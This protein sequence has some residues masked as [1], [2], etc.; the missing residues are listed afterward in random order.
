MAT[1]FL[2][3]ILKWRN[4]SSKKRNKNSGFTVLELL[5]ATLVA[6]FVIVALLDLVVDLLQTDRRE[7]A[8][9]ETQRE[10]Q[11]ALDFMVN[12]IREAAYIYDNNGLNGGGPDNLPGIK[13]YVQIPDGYT[14]ILAFW[15]PETISDADMQDLGDCGQFGQ[16]NEKRTECDLLLIR[17]RAFSLVIYMQK[18]NDRQDALGGWK[19][20]SRIARLQI[21]KYRLDGVGD[22]TKTTGY[23]DPQENTVTFATWPLDGNRTNRQ[24]GIAQGTTQVLVDFVD[25]PTESRTS[26]LYSDNLRA[27]D[28]PKC[29]DEQNYSQIPPT[30]GAAFN[31]P[32]FM[33]CVSTN[34][35]SGTGSDRSNANQDVLIFLRGNPTGKA[36]VK[37][38]PLLAVKTQAVARGVVDKQQGAQ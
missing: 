21:P 32:S 31:R 34:N 36:G 28:N 18:V 13:N 22:L 38:A 30:T 17:R 4:R 11:M 9:N 1:K 10:I 16:N 19:G 2:E 5:V 33:V 6:T 25:Y 15:K 27:P 8:R 29:P 37:V 3:T 20:V 12:D 14:P 26:P 35:T 24:S 7:Y 23:T